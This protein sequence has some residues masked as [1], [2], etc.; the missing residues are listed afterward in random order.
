MDGYLPHTAYRISPKH[1]TSPPTEK[2]KPEHRT[3]RTPGHTAEPWG[4]LAVAW[5]AGI[6]NELNK[7]KPACLAHSPPT[8]PSTVH[9]PLS[10]AHRPTTSLFPNKQTHFIFLHVTFYHGLGGI[11]G[12]WD[13]GIRTR[14]ALS[15]Q[16]V[17]GSVTR[18][19]C[20]ARSREQRRTW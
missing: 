9:C 15:L 7:N 6:P 11:V 10:T 14:W 2:Q 3:Q 8:N 13:S 4:S 19:E 12:L 16:R 5:A 18:R 20:N 17:T 1:I